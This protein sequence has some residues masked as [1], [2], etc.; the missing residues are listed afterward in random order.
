ML[1]CFIG[2]GQTSKRNSLT[3]ED[4]LSYWKG[5]EIQVGVGTEQSTRNY[6]TLYIGT[7]WIAKNNLTAEWNK[8][9]LKVAGFQKVTMDSGYGSIDQYILI[10]SASN[11]LKVFCDIEEAQSNGEIV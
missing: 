7:K 11:K 3:L 9:K 5:M 2:I 10:R 6:K 1:Y 8:R 4:G